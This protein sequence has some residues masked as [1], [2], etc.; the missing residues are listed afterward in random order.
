MEAQC[1]F[2]S[3]PSFS[4]ISH[5]SIIYTA[6]IKYLRVPD[7]LLDVV[8]EDQNRAREANRGS[9][10]G[11]AGARGT[12]SYRLTDLPLILIKLFLQGEVGCHH[13]VLRSVLY[14]I[15]IANPIIF[16]RWSRSAWRPGCAWWS[17]AWTR[18]VDVILTVVLSFCLCWLAV[19]TCFLVL[20]RDIYQVYVYVFQASTRIISH[21]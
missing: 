1:A 21:N 4:L 12:P 6:Q 18:N 13:E 10:G 14:I 17:W 11:H 20:T 5:Q 7:Q 8:K 19:S 16:C 9:R 3:T 15:L 2:V